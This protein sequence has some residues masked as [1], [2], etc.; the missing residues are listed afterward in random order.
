MEFFTGQCLC[1]E[2]K[3]EIA[4]DPYFPHLCSCHICQRWAGA[5]VVA[6]AE[7]DLN[8]VKWVG[9][10][11]E[12]N[13]YRSSEKTRRGSCGKCGSGVC[14][15]DDGSDSISITICTLDSP[16]IVTPS[17][18]HSFNDEVP[19]WYRSVIAATK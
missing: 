16:S 17:E 2:I 15:I 12:P 19:M 18:Q 14:A 7:F 3:Y 13:W 9:P 11:G 8:T 1:G 10:G 5:P 6:W 4:S